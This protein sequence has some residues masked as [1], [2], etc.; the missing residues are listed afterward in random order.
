[1]DMMDQLLQRQ[2]IKNLLNFFPVLRKLPQG[3]KVGRNR[4]MLETATRTNNKNKNTKNKIHILDQIMVGMKESLSL[5]FILSFWK[6][7]HMDFVLNLI[8]A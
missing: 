7:I 1:M 3:K 8:I 5:M 6:T 4:R 2:G